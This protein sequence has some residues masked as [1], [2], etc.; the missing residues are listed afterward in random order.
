MPMVDVRGGALYVEERGNGSPVLLIHGT[1]CNFHNWGNTGDRLAEHH[2]TIAYDR[3]G[4][5]RSNRSRTRDYGVHVRDAVE[6]LDHV[7]ARAATVVGWSSGGIVA[8]G[9]AL[10]KPSAVASLVLV[11]PPL[12]GQLHPTLDLL[13][14][15]PRVQMLTLRGRR[16]DATLTFLRW[17][18]SSS[19]GGNSFDTLSDELREEML[20][21]SAT[22]AAELTRPSR[23]P[24]SGEHLRRR[25]IES[26][27]CPIRY[28]Y[29]EWSNPWL[30]NAARRFER[31]H[32]A[33]RVVEIPGATHGL[34]GE[35]PDEFVR[36]VREA[37][38]APSLVPPR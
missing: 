36:H 27:A 1:G 35:V 7:G 26:L 8:L 30:K 6:L 32:P 9:L 37:A 12:H 20:A 31:W 34:P 23:H 38:L 10:A 2:R 17:I 16:R 14:R 22:T 19:A 28:L 4:Y 21:D 25:Q 24:G 3:R 5:G 29:G 15:Y 11:E 13:R 33:A 18:T